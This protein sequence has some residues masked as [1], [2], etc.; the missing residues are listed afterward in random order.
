MILG[1]GPTTRLFLLFRTPHFASVN[2][3]ISRIKSMKPWNGNTWEIQWPLLAQ[4]YGPASP[5]LEPLKSLSVTLLLL[6]QIWCLA[7]LREFSTENSDHPFFFLPSQGILC[8]LNKVSLYVE[9][10]L[11]QHDVTVSPFNFSQSTWPLASLQQLRRLESF[12]AFSMTSCLSENPC[13]HSLWQT[14]KHF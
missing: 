4:I 3:K 9:L 1:A 8:K 2:A 7:G 13:S 11:L 10:V 5:E 12:W 14:F 6:L